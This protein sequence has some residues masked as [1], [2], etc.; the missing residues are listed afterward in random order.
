MFQ[1]V[2]NGPSKQQAFDWMHSARARLATRSGYTG[3]DG[4]RT[5][6]NYAQGTE[7]LEQIYGA[8][9]LPRLAAL[10]RKWDPSNVFRYMNPLP[11]QYP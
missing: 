6:V 9:K 7:Q 1:P 4:L 8:D 11:T 10:K 2:S 3:Y 5:Y